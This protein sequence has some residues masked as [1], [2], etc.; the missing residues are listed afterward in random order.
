MAVSKLAPWTAVIVVVLTSA[1]AEAQQQGFPPRYPQLL[2][3]APGHPPA[4]MPAG[5]AP[6]AGAQFVSHPMPPAGQVPAAQFGSAPQYAPAAQFGPAPQ[7]G[8][9][10]QQVMPSQ[11]VMPSQ[12]AAAPQFGPAPQYQMAPGPQMASG[13]QYIVHEGEMPFSPGQEGKMVYMPEGQPYEVQE[14]YPPEGYMVSPYEGG[15]SWMGQNDWNWNGDGRKHSRRRGSHRCPD[16]NCDCDRG[17]ACSCGPGCG[18]GHGAGCGQPVWYMRAEA[19]WL[20]R[21]DPPTRNLTVYDNDGV[22]PLE[23]FIVLSTDDLDLGTALGMRWTLGRYLSERTSIEG[24]F[25]G[26]HDWDDRNSRPPHTWASRRRL[27][28]RS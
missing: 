3:Q 9:A 20:S 4:Q 12:Y 15:E 14:G 13:Q 21:N 10:P 19:V 28:P 26:L 6:P 25:Y 22:N 23:D 2:T 8:P 5:M 16:P 17:G 1:S 27:P 24:S 7:Y 11:H 18:A